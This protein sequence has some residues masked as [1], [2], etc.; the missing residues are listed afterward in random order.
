VV[1]Q[2]AVEK[3]RSVDPAQVR[4]ALASLDAMTFYGPVRFNAQGLNDRKPMVTVQIQ[5]GR[6]VTI[7]PREVAAAKAIYPTPPWSARK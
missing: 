2:L 4:E 6:V 1:L 3:A 5:Q 7:W